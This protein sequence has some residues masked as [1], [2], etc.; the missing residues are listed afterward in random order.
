VLAATVDVLTV[1]LALGASVVTALAA[2]GGVLLSGR[3]ETKRQRL[4]MQS[5]ELSE[6]RRIIVQVLG[7]GDQWAQLQVIIVPTAAL[8]GVDTLAEFVE[9]A[10]GQRLAVAIDELRIALNQARVAIV[11]PD[12]RAAVKVLHS[13]VEGFPDSIM[14]PV[15]RAA[16]DRND[17]VVD[18]LVAV[19]GFRNDLN[20]LADLAAKRLRSEIW[21]PDPALI[22]E[23]AADA[24]ATAAEGPIDGG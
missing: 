7:S 6:H 18:G 23:P 8:G 24:S 21:D 22:P 9:T 3:G 12:L 19:A 2:L 4:T 17:R 1:V 15:L 14:G 20:T 16:H 13:F 10:S 5:A 11:D